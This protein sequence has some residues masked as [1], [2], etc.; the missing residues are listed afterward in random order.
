MLAIQPHSL[1]RSLFSFFTALCILSLVIGCEAGPRLIFTP[2][3]EQTPEVATP[4]E[5]PSE[6]TDS[7]SEA[8]DLPV[9]ASTQYWVRYQDWKMSHLD[10]EHDLD[11]TSMSLRN[12]ESSFA[13]VER[14]FKAL[15]PAIPEPV[16]AFYKEARQAYADIR[17]SAARDLNRDVI[18]QRIRSLGDKAF[19]HLKP[20][21]I[22]KIQATLEPEAEKDEAEPEADESESPE[23]PE[24]S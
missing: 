8:L 15:S 21:A 19:Q 6:S 16:Q 12:M 14:E 17:E 5:T 24:E 1:S 11:N 9:K 23:A 7:V 20:T 2:G 13:A 18:R 10:L 4:S 22:A 3:P